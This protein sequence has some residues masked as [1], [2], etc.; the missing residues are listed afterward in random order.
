M[1]I[2]SKIDEYILVDMYDISIHGGKNEGITC[3][4][5]IREL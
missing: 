3:I 5:N 2:S 4:H 1:S